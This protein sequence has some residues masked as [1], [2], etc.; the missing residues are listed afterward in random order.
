MDANTNASI[1][2]IKISVSEHSESV[3]VWDN[4][5]IR[6]LKIKQNNL[7]IEYEEYEKVCVKS[8]KGYRRAITRPLFSVG[9]IAGAVHSSAGCYCHPEVKL[10]QQSTHC[11]RS[12]CSE[13]SCGSRALVF[14]C[15]PP[16]R[17]HCVTRR[18]SWCSFAFQSAWENSGRMQ[19]S[20]KYLKKRRLETMV[21]DWDRKGCGWR[22]LANKQN[23]MPTH[24]L[25]LN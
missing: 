21:L 15:P 11:H 12:P 18:M 2:D 25:K 1:S 10:L 17:C 22:L 8:C 7:K 13:A 3:F 14:I 9:T 6:N 16:T 24:T 19:I 23:L 4:V 5:S 20:L